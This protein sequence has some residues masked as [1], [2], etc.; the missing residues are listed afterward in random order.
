[1]SK[2]EVEKA[3]GVPLERA[4]SSLRFY[5]NQPGAD[6]SR[7]QTWKAE[8][9][10]FLGRPGTVHYTFLNDRLFVFHIFVTDPD[11]EKLD[12]DM[13][14]YL[15]HKFGSDFGT[16]EDDPALKRIWEDGQRIVNYWFYERKASLLGRYKAGYGVLYRA[17]ENQAPIDS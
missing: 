7:Y 15:D 4:S 12:A 10:R 11:G 16:E 2:A 17:L 6:D 5:K 9:Q 13:K 1:M 8:G 14:N 3:N